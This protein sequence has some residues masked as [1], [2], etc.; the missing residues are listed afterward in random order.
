MSKITAL[1]AMTLFIKPLCI[2]EDGQISIYE[3]PR[4]MKA[5]L[6][7]LVNN[8]KEKCTDFSGKCIIT[9][10][11]NEENANFVKKLIEEKY[12]FNEVIIRP[13]KG[14]CSFYA[15]ENGIIVSF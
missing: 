1:V 14:L 7:R 15:L 8:I 10:C 12:N 13:M 9:H 6:I 2:A 11:H 4:T 3:K 5:A